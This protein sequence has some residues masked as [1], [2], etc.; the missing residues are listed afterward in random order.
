MSLKGMNTTAS[1]LQAGNKK[2]M[3]SPSAKLPIWNLFLF[4][5]NSNRLNGQKAASGILFRRYLKAHALAGILESNS[6]TIAKAARRA[7]RS[8]SSDYRIESGL[9]LSIT[10]ENLAS[11]SGL[12]CSCRDQAIFTEGQRYKKVSAETNGNAVSNLAMPNRILSSTTVKDS[13]R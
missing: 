3:Q 2:P 11:A 4:I 9:R 1:C 12:H 5:W 10:K 7:E 6:P 8:S 13:E